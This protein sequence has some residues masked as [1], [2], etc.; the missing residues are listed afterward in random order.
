MGL[1]PKTPTTK[2]TKIAPNYNSHQTPRNRIKHIFNNYRLPRDH[3][4]Q[5]FQM[6]QSFNFRMQETGNIQTQQDTE[7]TTHSFYIRRIRAESESI[8][9]YASRV[10]LN[11]KQTLLVCDNKSRKSCIAH[12]AYK[13]MVAYF[14]QSSLLSTHWLWQKE[15]KDRTPSK[16]VYPSVL[17]LA[18]VF[19][20]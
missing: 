9:T 4:E 8:E 12:L 5:I 14:F 2:A 17:L 6:N 18:E 19:A 16:S 11:H 7:R 15:V 13:L 20:P 1:Q 10:Y 3:C